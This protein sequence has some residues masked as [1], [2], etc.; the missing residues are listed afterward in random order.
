[1]NNER[2]TKKETQELQRR[3]KEEKM[4]KGQCHGKSFQTETVGV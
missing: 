1:M 3:E 2:K 4:L